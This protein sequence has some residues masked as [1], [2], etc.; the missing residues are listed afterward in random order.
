MEKQIKT[1]EAVISHP[2]GWL[3]SRRQEITSFALSRKRDAGEA[4]CA[5][6]LMQLLGKHGIESPKETKKKIKPFI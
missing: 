3:L 1:R 5:C 2:H 6:K 4:W